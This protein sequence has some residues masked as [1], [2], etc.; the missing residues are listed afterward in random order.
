MISDTST[1]E[2][3]RILRQLEYESNFKFSYQSLDVVVETEHQE[4]LSVPK[5]NAQIRC[6]EKARIVSIC[7]ALVNNTPG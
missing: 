4:V 5:D 1:G 7:S 2:V 6:R 3:S